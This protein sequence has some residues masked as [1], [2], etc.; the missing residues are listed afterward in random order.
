MSGV[1]VSEGLSED[2]GT[3]EGR[4]TR[5]KCV[6]SWWSIRAE[7]QKYKSKALEHWSSKGAG[8]GGTILPGTKEAGG[9]REGQITQP[10]GPL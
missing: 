8:V 1:V 4:I 9:G 10:L 7:E 5:T 2:I 3:E 6:K